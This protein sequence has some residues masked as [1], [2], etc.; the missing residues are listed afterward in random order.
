MNNKM[1]LLKSRALMKLVV[2]Q[3]WGIKE[4]IICFYLALEHI[5]Q[6]DKRFEQLLK[7]IFTLGLYDVNQAYKN[8]S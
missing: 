2:E 4:K 1:S 3:F 7:E 5:F 6:K 8:Y